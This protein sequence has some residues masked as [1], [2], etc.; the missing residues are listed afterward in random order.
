MSARRFQLLRPK[1]V[2]LER[3]I[4]TMYNSAILGGKNGFDI[5]IRKIVIGKGNYWLRRLNS[6]RDEILTIIMFSTYIGKYPLN[7]MFWITNFSKI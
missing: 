4:G 7:E 3:I 6:F 5:L 2:F 1:Q